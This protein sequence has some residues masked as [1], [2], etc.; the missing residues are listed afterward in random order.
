MPIAAG[1]RLGKGAHMFAT[2]RAA[3]A[4]ERVKSVFLE[5]PGAKLSVSDASRLC[6]IE[7]GTCGAVLE[8]LE[9]ARFLVRGR[10]GLF[11]RRAPDSPVFD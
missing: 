5:S 3:N 8:A 4:L 7:R 1:D 6:G 2:D 11:G 10:D 9:H